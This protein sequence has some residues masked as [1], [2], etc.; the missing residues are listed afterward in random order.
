VEAA[1]ADGSF[2]KLFYFY[3]GPQIRQARLDKRVLINLPNPLLSPQ[4]PLNRRELWFT[5]EDLKRL[6]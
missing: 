6:P 1:L 4:T 5:L 3:Y 2:E